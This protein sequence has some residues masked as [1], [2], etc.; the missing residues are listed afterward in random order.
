MEPGKRVGRG[1]K[2][3]REVPIKAAA[4]E[5]NLP[6]HEID[7]F[8]GW[9]PPRPQG[10][11][12]N[13][14]IAVSFGLLVPPR[15]L[16]GA[17][18]GG[19]NVHPSLLPDFRGAAPIHHALLAGEK[20]T[21]IT[22]Q[23]L[24]PKRMDHGVILDQTPPPGFDI[25]SP[26]SCT[27]DQLLDFVTPKAAE[28]LLGGI[29]NQVF[30]PP[31]KGIGWRAESDEN[32]LRFAGKIKKEDL[33]INWSDYSWEEIKRRERVLGPLWSKALVPDTS[34]DGKSFQLKRIIFTKM[35]IAEGIDFLDPIDVPAGQLFLAYTKF[36]V[37]RRGKRMFVYTSD[38]KLVQ[39]HEMKVEGQ[40]AGDAY[41]AALKSGLVQPRTSNEGTTFYSIFHACLQ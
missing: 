6:V 18:Y 21:G 19:L 5:L 37:S 31:L 22:L 28:M 12:I 29:Q 20:K 39:I 25:P 1:L 2:S 4:N 9:S 41:T 10:E 16:N 32:E 11:P 24:H 34:T 13:L 30:V 26:E 33:H 14:V 15:I 23:T 3:I 35:D 36:P 8:T 17:K 40:P 38:G 7:T 27:V